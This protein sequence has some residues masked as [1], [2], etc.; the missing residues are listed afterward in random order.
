MH[1]H[2]A[3]KSILHS[4]DSESKTIWKDFCKPYE[5]ID[6]KLSTDEAYHS[7]TIVPADKPCLLELKSIEIVDER[8]Q[9]VPHTMEGNYSVVR[10]NRIITYSDPI[11]IVLRFPSS[12]RLSRIRLAFAILLQGEEVHAMR[13]KHSVREWLRSN[14]VLGPLL[15]KCSE[16]ST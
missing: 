9:N 15:S 10:N 16:T 13:V 3:P 12:H 8:G 6:L 11:Q 7:I 14:P 2:A 5:E 4:S 1:I